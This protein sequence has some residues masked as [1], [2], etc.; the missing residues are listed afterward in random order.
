MNNAFSLILLNGTPVDLR[1]FGTPRQID[2]EGSAGDRVRFEVSQDGVTYR[3]VPNSLRSADDT[4]KFQWIVSLTFNYIRAFPV[5]SAAG[6]C[7]ITAISMSANNP[8]IAL[9]VP[10]VVGTTGAFVDAR[11]LGF[12]R[13]LFFAGISGD[14]FEIQARDGFIAPAWT[15]YTGTLLETGGLLIE[16]GATSKGPLANFYRVKRLAG[17]TAAACGLASLPNAL[18]EV[19]PGPITPAFVTVNDTAVPG[20]LGTPP[21]TAAESVDLASLLQ[22]TQT[23]AAIDATM[24]APAADRQI[25]FIALDPASTRPLAMYGDIIGP[26]FF[27]IKLWNGAAWSSLGYLG[28]GGNSYGFALRIGSINNQD[29]SLIRNDAIFFSS[30]GTDVTAQP[31]AA[32]GVLNVQQTGPAPGD[33]GGVRFWATSVSIGQWVTLR[34]PDTLAANITIT[35]PAALPTINGQVAETSTAGV[36]TYRGVVNVIATNTSAQTIADGGGDT[37]VTGYTEVLDTANAF[38]PATGAFVVPVGGG[39]LYSISFGNQFAATAADLGVTFTASVAV[40]GVNARSF[41]FVNPVAALAQTRALAG[42]CKLQLADGDQINIHVALS[43]NG[44]VDIALTNSAL[45]NWLQIS[46]LGA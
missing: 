36:Q 37:D 14:A 16:L 40:G 15:V 35:L 31:G 33:G 27:T 4:G 28:V 13:T 11:A 2:Y 32:G 29:V 5:G 6:W 41:E 23:T 9:A 20:N 30:N 46:R 21:L 10:V 42:E 44:G 38:T 24:P 17:T 34:A 18:P 19:T 39:G 7:G 45:F 43:A 1:R 26:G 8:T 22:P 12:P 25:E 3:A